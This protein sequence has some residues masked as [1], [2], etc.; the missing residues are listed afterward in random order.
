MAFACF[1]V[2]D[3]HARGFM[4]LARYISLNVA[5]A[6][7]RRVLG[8]SVARFDHLSS[9]FYYILFDFKVILC[10]K[11]IGMDRL[12]GAVKKSEKRLVELHRLQVEFSM[13]N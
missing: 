2:R 12:Y 6:Y 11:R 5:D 13:G 9:R 4:E 10:H 7:G 1:A 3:F 8:C